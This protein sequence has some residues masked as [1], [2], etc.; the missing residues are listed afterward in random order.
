MNAELAGYIDQ[1]QKMYR[2]HSA[3]EDTVIFPAFDLMEKRSDLEELT[4]T[5]GDEEKKVLGRNGYDVFL[6]QIAH[7]EK[8]LGIYELSSSTPKLG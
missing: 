1:F 3:Y 2:H 6:N 8:Q 5:F 7:V 4:A